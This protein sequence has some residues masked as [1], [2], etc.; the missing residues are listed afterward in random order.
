MEREVQEH[1]WAR[2]RGETERREEKDRLVAVRE[3]RMRGEEAAVARRGPRVT[4]DP[5]GDRPP[6]DR[7]GLSPSTKRARRDSDDVG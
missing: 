5:H 3:R 4:R 2:I 6:T 7:E 1:A